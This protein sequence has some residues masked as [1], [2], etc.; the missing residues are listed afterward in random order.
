MIPGDRPENLQ[1]RRSACQPPFLCPPI[2]AGANRSGSGG[3]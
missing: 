2:D 1:G 3:L